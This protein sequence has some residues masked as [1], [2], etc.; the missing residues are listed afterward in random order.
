MRHTLWKTA[1]IIAV[2]TSTLRAEHVEVTSDEM[3]AFDTIKEIHF[4]GD[5]NASQ[6]KNWI[7]GNRIVVYLTQDNKAKEYVVKGNVTFRID[8]AGGLYVGKSDTATYDPKTSVYV[9]IGHAVVDDLRNKRHLEGAKIVLN[10]LTGHADV[11]S[12]KGKGKRKKPV[13]FTFEAGNS[14]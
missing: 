2:L 6:G 11:K 13:K 8:H 1:F 9:L 14:K 10:T 12:G 7:H 3:K 4:I 5:A